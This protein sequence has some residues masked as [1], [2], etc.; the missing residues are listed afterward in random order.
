MASDRRAF[1]D[2]EQVLAHVERKVNEARLRGE[3]IDYITFAPSG[4]PTLDVNLGREISLL[5]PLGYPIAV[6]TN[7]SLL[8]RDDVMRELMAADLVSVKVDAVSQELWKR[9]NRPHE[10]LKLDEV[11]DGIKELSKAFSGALISETMLID[12]VSREGELMEIAGFLKSLSKL[13]RAYIAIPTRP[14]AEKW[15][16][17]A[18]EAVLN[19]AFQTFTEELGDSRVEYLIGYEGDNFAFTGDVEHELLSI[20]AVHPMRREAV[21]ELL[22]KAKAGWRVVERLLEEGKLLELEYEGRSYYMRKLSSQPRDRGAQE[23]F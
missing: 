15:V 17:P 4:E 13:D 9:I 1:H 6:I 10:D 2:P 7:A 11:L 14:P 12:G 18:K 5:K 16:K 23:R 22:R 21:M 3:R 8:W 19:A 20:T